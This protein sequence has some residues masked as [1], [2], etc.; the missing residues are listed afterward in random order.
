MRTV[1]EG[2]GRFGG[3]HTFLSVSVN[4]GGDRRGVPGRAEM[5]WPR[6]LDR[7]Y[8]T[9][10]SLGGRASRTEFRGVRQPRRRVTGI[11][12]VLAYRRLGPDGHLHD[13]LLR[14]AARGRWW[15]YWQLVS[16]PRDVGPGRRFLGIRRAGAQVRRR[17]TLAVRRAGPR[18]RFMGQASDRR[19]AGPPLSP[20]RMAAA[21]GR[22]C[23]LCSSG[24]RDT[25]GLAPSSGRSC[26]GCRR[27]QRAARAFS[28]SPSR[29]G[30][31]LPDAGYAASP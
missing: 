29:T 21:A 26:S 1:A 23:P 19:G 16:K 17:T 2:P 3:E 10:A 27:R 7:A 15:R 12:A 20:G 13:L 4:R 28:G 24:G 31:L 14:V 8:L 18:T 5:W 30:A 25:A 22:C 9:G 11:G 6:P